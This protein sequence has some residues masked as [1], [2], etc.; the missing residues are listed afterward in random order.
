LGAPCNDITGAVVDKV[1]CRSTSGDCAPQLGLNSG[2]EL[3][4]PRR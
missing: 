4:L 1:V 2:A 3:A